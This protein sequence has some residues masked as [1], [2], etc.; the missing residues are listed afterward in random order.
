MIPIHATAPTGT[1]TLSARVRRD[2]DG[3][4]LDFADGVFKAAGHASP[5]AALVEVDPAAFPGLFRASLAPEGP[6]VWTDGRYIVQ[7][8]D[9]AA[10]LEYDPSPLDVRDGRPVEGEPVEV[11]GLARL[12]SSTDD[13]QVVFWLMAGGRLHGTPTSGTVTIYNADGTVFAGPLVDLTPDAQGVFTVEEL[14]AG[15]APDAAYYAVAS[16]VAGGVTYR[17]PVAFVVYDV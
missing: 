12:K 3:F 2:A 15:T 9:S 5:S 11:Q 13:L 14:A 4:F 17:S 6:P 16:V 10:A 1:A 8:R 7:V